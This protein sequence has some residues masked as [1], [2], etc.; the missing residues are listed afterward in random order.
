MKW[1]EHHM[2]AVTLH[3]GG[4]S[5]WLVRGDLMFAD[6]HIREMV[7]DF[8]VR[9]LKN[10]KPRYVLGI[11]GGGVPWAKAL[12]DRVEDLTYV[13]PDGE[14]PEYG[15]VVVVDD[16]ATTGNSLQEFRPDIVLRAS[17]VVVHRANAFGQTLPA[18]PW[19]R[20]HLP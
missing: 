18:I 2:E 20:M 12:A 10:V 17:L 4:K 14:V 15:E 13:E 8:W 19:M 11:P 1:L 16:V 3:S 7:L 6:E 9:C 5:H